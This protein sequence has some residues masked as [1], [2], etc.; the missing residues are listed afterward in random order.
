YGIM[1]HL[2]EGYAPYLGAI[3]ESPRGALIAMET[4]VTTSYALDNAQQRGILFVGPGVPVYV[5]MVVGENSR[6]TDLELNVCR[7]KHVTNMRS[8]TSDESVR[9][10]PPRPLTLDTALEYVKADELVEITPKNIRLRKAN[11]DSTA[12]KRAGRG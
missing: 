7:K 6:P 12:R 11:L 2:F 5:G 1:N 8:A 4:G 10:T 3:E 9:L